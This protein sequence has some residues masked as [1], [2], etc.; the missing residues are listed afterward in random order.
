MVTRGGTRGR[1]GDGDHERA[2]A[3]GRSPNIND[4]LARVARLKGDPADRDAGGRFAKS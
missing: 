4:Y 3:A 1:V 2:R